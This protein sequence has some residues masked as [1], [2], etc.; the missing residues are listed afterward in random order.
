MLAVA[1][2]FPSCMLK[3]VSPCKTEKCSI[4]MYILTSLLHSQREQERLKKIVEKKN[5]QIAERNQCRQ[6]KV[7]Q[8]TELVTAL[9]Q[10]C[11]EREEK[12]AQLENELKSLAI[13]LAETSARQHIRSADKATITDELT[14]ERIPSPSL[15][16]Q[17]NDNETTTAKTHEAQP[18]RRRVVRSGKNSSASTLPPTPPRSGSARRKTSG[19]S[20]Y[21]QLPPWR[22]FAIT[23]NLLLR[24]LYKSPA[25]TNIN[26]VAIA[27]AITGS[28]YYDIAD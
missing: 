11:K 3:V 19:M 27:L 18:R 14:N 13:N 4:A 10:L 16:D 6:E 5:S 1:I 21:S 2:A 25:K 17:Q 20:R 24:I 22:H 26:C 9:T 15:D 7:Q 28:R 23:N 12:V 8:D